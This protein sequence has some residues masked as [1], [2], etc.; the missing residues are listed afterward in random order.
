VTVFHRI[1]DRFFNLAGAMEINLH[2]DARPFDPKHQGPGVEIIS[3]AGYRREFYGDQA[4][5]I[6]DYFEGRTLSTINAEVG[7]GAVVV[8]VHKSEPAEA[9]ALH[10]THQES[11]SCST[12]GIVRDFTPPS[13]P[14][15]ATPSGPRSPRTPAPS[16]GCPAGDPTAGSTR[17][18]S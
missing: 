3:V 12:V 11:T 8:E 18:A 2:H 4:Q 15:P 6:R 10:H 17:D 9:I 5:A 14:G 7:F 13:G 16:A 1:G